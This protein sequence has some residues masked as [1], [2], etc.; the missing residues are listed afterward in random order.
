NLNGAAVTAR[1]RVQFFAADGGG[2]APGTL[3]LS[4][5]FPPTTFGPGSVSLLTSV[6]LTPGQFVLPSVFW[7]GV[8]F[9]DNSGSTGATLAEL[10]NFG[11]GTFNPPT[12]G[13]S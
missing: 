8:V 7:A 1:P 6:P 2:N 12:A 5:A 3:L 13:S 10:N 11:Q 4:L 9:D